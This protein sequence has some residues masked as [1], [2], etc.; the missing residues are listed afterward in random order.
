MREI[1]YIIQNVNQ[2]SIVIIDELGRG[3]YY[4]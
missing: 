2:S 1:N 4:I 3:E